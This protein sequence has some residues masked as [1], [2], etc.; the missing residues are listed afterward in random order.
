MVS[1]VYIK[2]CLINYFASAAVAVDSSHMSAFSSASWSKFSPS[3]NFVNGHVSTMWFKVC[4]WASLSQIA[5]QQG[6]LARP[7][8]CQYTCRTI[9]K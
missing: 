9:L 6:D 3:T 5:S 7:H 1:D 2:F 4:H 8:F